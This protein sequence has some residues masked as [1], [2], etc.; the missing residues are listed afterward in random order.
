MASR[1]GRQGMT[2][3]GTSGTAW[4]WNGTSAR[5]GQERYVRA[6]TARGGLSA[7]G[8]LFMAW[9]VGVARDW[10]GSGLSRGC[11][12]ERIDRAGGQVCLWGWAGFGSVCR[13]GVDRSGMSGRGGTGSGRCGTDSRLVGVVR[14][15]WVCRGRQDPGPACRRDQARTDVDSRFG[16]GWCVT[17]RY[18]GVA[19][20]GV[21]VVRRHGKL[22]DG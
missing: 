4:R 14:L 11:G 15:G 6:D 2:G 10:R 16:L 5:M 13:R 3:N 17:G 1:D 22:R 18:V 21:P 19:R 12:V 8:G 20:R 7:W 9:H